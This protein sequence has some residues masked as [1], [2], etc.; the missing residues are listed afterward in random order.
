MLSGLY[1]PWVLIKEPSTLKQALIYFD[2]VALLYPPDPTQL[3]GDIRSLAGRERTN[4]AQLAENASRFIESCRP[5]LDSGVMELIDPS[6]VASSQQDREIL[7]R[8]V[9]ADITDPSFLRL[10]CDLKVFIEDNIMVDVGPS[11][12]TFDNFY[13]FSFDKLA[14][15]LEK[16]L[17]TETKRL[18]P[19]MQRLFYS[20]YPGMSAE[21]VGQSVMLNKTVMAA[22]ALD[23][24]PFSDDPSHLEVLHNKYVRVLDHYCGG[25]S[26][27]LSAWK[28][29][30]QMRKYVS[31]V[32]LIEVVL[33]NL[34]TLN[35]DDLLEIRLKLGDELGLFR[36]E[37]DSLS[38]QLKCEVLDI[39]FERELDM[40][41]RQKVVPSIEQLKRRLELADKKIGLKLIKKLQSPQPV[42]PFLIS[43]FSPIP[44]YAALLVS[45]GIITLEVAI[46]TYLEKSEIRN[47]TGLSYLLNFSKKP[48][49][50]QGLY[51]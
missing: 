22:Q 1:F 6:A 47:T 21:R 14:R 8:S 26:S 16:E 11:G 45:A 42:I 13:N 31:A 4:L 33:P 44:L 28:A 2:K 27:A 15:K 9:F 37:V 43:A 23:L 5:L 12:W 17:S 18:S 38:S 29:K 19:R 34:E 24:V 51:F 3:E 35:V 7:Y 50:Y 25:D 10:D 36:S 46:E 20:H 49:V 48:R 41:V 30:Q 40:Q 32:K 39:E